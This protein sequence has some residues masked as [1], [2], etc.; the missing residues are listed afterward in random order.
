MAEKTLI[1]YVLQR[2]FAKVISTLQDVNSDKC[3]VEKKR[4]LR[5]LGPSASIY[6][7][8]PSLDKEGLLRVGGRLENA[9]IEYDEKHQL[10]LPNRHKLTEMS[11][12]EEEHEVMGHVGKEHV[13]S[14]LRR[15]YW[16]GRAAVRKVIG[17]CFVCKRR[18]ARRMNQMM[19]NLPQD[20]V[21]PDDPPF[22]YIG[23]DLFGPISVRQ[24]RSQVKRYVHV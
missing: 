1:M 8:S 15:A 20:G 14:R 18:G 23:I 21:S 22:T 3:K 16:I 19:A 5:I 4:A 24:K 12:R 10:I 9:P 7:L 6:K 2:T 11:I 17:D 13:L